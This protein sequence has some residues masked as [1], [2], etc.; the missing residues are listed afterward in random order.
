MSK[1]TKEEIKSVNGADS[2]IPT[3]EGA[4]A[5]IKS[6][7]S[8]LE[9]NPEV[10][11]AMAAALFRDKAISPTN[12]SKAAVRLAKGVYYREAFAK[13]L[14]PFL[15][16]IIATNTDITFPYNKYPSYKPSTLRARIDQ[17]FR[18]VIEHLDPDLKY[19][20]LKAH[21][22]ISVEELG[23]SIR[24]DK[25]V[26]RLHGDLVAEDIVPREVTHTWKQ[27]LYDWLEIEWNPLL[28]KE[29]CKFDKPNLALSQLDITELEEL[30][31]PL[32]PSIQGQ[33]TANR[34]FLVKLNPQVAT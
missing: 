23:V 16:R 28:S 19:L 9:A 10:K 5:L 3:G 29:E 32:H 22:T 8:L 12:E 14:I 26:I 21:V 1:L 13:Q 30:I 31:Q 7:A 15:D 25:N 17:S 20:D 6:L 24:H 34:I 11:K 33:I 18:Y 4:I 2:I 27:P